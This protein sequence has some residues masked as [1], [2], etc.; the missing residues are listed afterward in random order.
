VGQ[1]LHFIVVEDDRHAAE[2]MRLLLQR[3]GHRVDVHLDAGTAVEHL[4]S[5]RPD[6]VLI[7]IMMPGMDGIEICRRI[8]SAPEL[9]ALKTVVVTGKVYDTDRA[10]AMAAGARGVILKPINP[11]TFAQ[12]V[13][14]LLNDDITMSYWGVRGLMPVPGASTN[15][16]GGNTACIA[17]QLPCDTLL[18]LEAGTGLKKLSDRLIANEG[19]RIKGRVL[20]SHPRWDHINA[21]PFFEPLYRGGNEFEIMGPAQGHATMRDLAMAQFDPLYSMKNYRDLSARVFFRDLPERT[22]QVGVATIRTMLLAHPGNCLGY[23]IEYGGRTIC[24]IPAT[25]LPE[26]TASNYNSDFETK[27]AD[28]ITGAN[29]VILG[30]ASCMQRA[31]ELVHEAGVQELHLFHHHPD[32]DDIAIDAKLANM[33]TTLAALNS[34]VVCSAP[35]EGMEYALLGTETPHLERVA[36]LSNAA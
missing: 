18:I 13:V 21:L 14:A 25:D 2:A 8:H 4:R 31:A 28:F 23:R 16:Y 17:L 35:H 24:Y 7:D 22:L 36:A 12:D 11:K 19:E 9:S 33:R 27:F 30:D 6:V 3:E 34:A 32:E 1:P 20:I 5:A 10:R 26:P 15:R 29:V